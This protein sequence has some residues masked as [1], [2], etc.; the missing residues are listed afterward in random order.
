MKTLTIQTTGERFY[1]ITDEVAGVLPS[2]LPSPDAS[3]VLY[4]YCPHTSCALTITESFEDSAVNDMQEFLK[5]AAP[6]ESSFI[7]HTTEGLDDSPSHM[8]SILLQTTLMIFVES[9]KL[10]MGQWQGI[11]LCEFRDGSKSR[12]IWPKFILG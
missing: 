11:F 12:Q 10:K 2:L 5:R 4:L 3:G 8:K 6:R 9:G 1:S 7:T